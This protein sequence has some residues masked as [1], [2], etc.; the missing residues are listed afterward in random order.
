LFPSELVF[1][2]N[3]FPFKSY[4]LATHCTRHYF[5]ISDLF[6]L[7]FELLQFSDYLTVFALR[8]EWLF[9][10]FTFAKH[11]CL[12]VIPTFLKFPFTSKLPPSSIRYFPLCFI[13]WFIFP[14]LF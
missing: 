2:F 5:H 4:F 6:Q 13:R 14:S 9:L 3:Y 8:W 10:F 1:Q 7:I 12:L 11:T